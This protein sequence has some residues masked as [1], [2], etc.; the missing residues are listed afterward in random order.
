M[1][2]LRKLARGAAKSVV[3]ASLFIYPVAIYFA[4]DYLSPTQ[5]LAGLLFLLA[6][7]VALAAWIKPQHHNRDLVVA[8]LLA[9]AA[10]LVLLFLPHVR[11]D[12]LRLYPAL[13]SL[14]VFVMFFG[15]LFTAQPMVERIARVMHPDLPPQA[16]A[17]CRRVT[18]V[19]CLV[20]AANVLVSL[21]TAFATSLRFW[22]LYNGVIIYCVFGA[23]LLGEYLLRLRLQRKWEGA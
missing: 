20:L 11:L 9:V 3:V 18:R 2:P 17:H 12:W 13:I 14:V 22:S 8:A 16:V 5:L 10:F 23:M 21:Y 1:Q 19:W 15:S 6:S 7:R 4:A